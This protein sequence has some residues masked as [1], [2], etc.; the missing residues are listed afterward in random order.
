MVRAVKAN[1][2]K[3]LSVS[4]LNSEL[5]ELKKELFKLRFQLA[6]NNL[7]NPMRV[8]SV[9]KDIARIKTVM[10]ERQLKGISD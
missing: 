9:K 5:S 6:T 10:K 1:K 3:E 2:I 7:D 8:K 4:E